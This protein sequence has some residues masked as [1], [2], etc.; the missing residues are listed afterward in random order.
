[1]SREMK[2]YFILFRFGQIMSI[3]ALRDIRVDE[4]ILVN[5]NYDVKLAPE[6]YRSLWMQHFHQVKSEAS[7]ELTK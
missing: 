1:M 6:W 7:E 4:E 5:Y 3:V 2:S